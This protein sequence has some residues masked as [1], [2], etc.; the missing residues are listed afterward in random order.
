[1]ALSLD[2]KINRARVKQFASQ[3]KQVSQNARAWFEETFGGDNS[4]EFYEG[5]LSAYANMHVMVQNLPPEQIKNLSGQIVAFVAN[6]LQK[7][8]KPK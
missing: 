2:E 1:M 5:L 8:Y 4:I 6:E 3:M 7:K